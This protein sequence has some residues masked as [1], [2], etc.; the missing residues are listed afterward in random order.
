MKQK[1][2][3]FPYII[4][5]GPKKN[6]IESYYI[7]VEQ[8]LIKVRH[9]PRSNYIA[10]LLQKIIIFIVLTDAENICDSQM[11]NGYTILQTFDV[12]F[13]VHKIFD[14]NF[15]KNIINAMHFIE[16]YLYKMIDK[17]VSITTRMQDI[18]NRIVRQ[19]SS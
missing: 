5:Y 7:D 11:P 6:S 8:H 2:N 3:L 9:N 17:N 4:A 14:L 13:K 1:E 19:F 18:H 12:F 16:H 15:D 10:I